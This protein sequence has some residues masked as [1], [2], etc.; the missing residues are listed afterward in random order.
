MDTHHRKRPLTFPSTILIGKHS[1]CY[2]K[3][4][5]NPHGAKGTGVQPVSWEEG[6]KDSPPDVHGV[7]TLIDNDRVWGEE[8]VDLEREHMTVT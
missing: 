7:S 2:S 6:G 1:S 4:T 3:T 8:L 5:P